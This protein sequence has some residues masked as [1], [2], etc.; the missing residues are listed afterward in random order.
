[1]QWDRQ[2]LSSGTGKLAYHKTNQSNQPNQSRAHALEM[3][4]EVSCT[5]QRTNQFNNNKRLYCRIILCSSNLLSRSL[6]VSCKVLPRGWGEKVPECVLHPLCVIPF[7]HSAR[8][9]RSNTSNNLNF[10]TA[11]SKY[12]KSQA[13]KNKNAW[14]IYCDIFSVSRHLLHRLTNIVKAPL[15]WKNLETHHY[16]HLTLWKCRPS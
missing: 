6:Q 16:G 8:G 3:S 11:G 4:S 2:R 9:K 10:A 7:L 12:K 15:L 14:T 1:M 5:R 13:G